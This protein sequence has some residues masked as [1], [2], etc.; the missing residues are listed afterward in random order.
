MPEFTTISIE[1][2]RRVTGGARRQQELAAYIE[3]VTDLPPGTA[4][5]ATPSEG[6]T[7]AMVR[8]RL[9]DAAR[10]SGRDLEIRRTDDAVYYWAR[11]PKRRGRPRMAR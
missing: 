6:E 4:G 7:L 1:E 8:R 3:S 2:A 10:A 11:E 5:M 9:G